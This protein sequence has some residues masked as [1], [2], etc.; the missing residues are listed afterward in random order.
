MTDGRVIL[1]RRGE[2]LAA[3]HLSDLG[4]TITT[5]NY[6]C[7]LGE[8]DIIADDAGCVVICEVKTLLAGGGHP[9]E[10]VTPRKQDRLRRLGDYYWQFETDRSKPLRFDV[11]AVQD[12]DGEILIDHVRDAF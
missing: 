7:P 11:V 6:R 4:Y 9:L 5:R 10:A 1:G 8:I 3:E 12:R 2:D